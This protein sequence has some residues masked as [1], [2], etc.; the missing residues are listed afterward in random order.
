MGNIPEPAILVRFV[1]LSA[2]E[3]EERRR[4]LSALLLRGALRLA[5][6]AQQPETAEVLVTVRK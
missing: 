3:M 4:R 5:R 6:Q 2:Q 1:P